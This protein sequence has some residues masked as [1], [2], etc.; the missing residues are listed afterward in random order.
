MK[1]DFLLSIDLAMRKMK[2]VMTLRNFSHSTYKAYEGCLRRFLAQYADQLNNPNQS[3]IKDFLCSLFNNGSSAQTV[4]SYLQA[5]RF[6]YRE[7][8]QAPIKINIKGP[9]R[10]SRLPITLTHQEIRI[11]ALSK[12]CSV[13]QTSERHNVIHMSQPHHFEQ[14]KARFD[15]A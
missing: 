12:N 2:R 5:F 13:T 1:T 7:V 14:L 11:F 9:K 8:A 6:Y 15:H 10:P 3:I 4:Q